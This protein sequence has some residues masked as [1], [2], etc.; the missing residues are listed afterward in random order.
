MDEE[1]GRRFH[2]FKF[3]DAYLLNGNGEVEALEALTDIK[4]IFL[5]IENSDVKVIGSRSIGI[6]RR[7]FK[8]YWQG[9]RTYNTWGQGIKLGKEIERVESA[10]KQ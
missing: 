6:Y 9:Q 5:S 7:R 3:C 8:W 10:L 1:R 4:G 2:V